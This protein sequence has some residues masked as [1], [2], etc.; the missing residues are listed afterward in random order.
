MPSLTMAIS[1]FVL[2][3]FAVPIV[4]CKSIGGQYYV[5]PNDTKTCVNDLVAWCDGMKFS[6]ERGSISMVS[7][8]MVDSTGYSQ[9]LCIADSK[10][11][12]CTKNGSPWLNCSNTNQLFYK[13]NALAKDSLEGTDNGTCE[14][15]DK[16]F[17]DLSVQNLNSDNSMDLESGLGQF[18]REL[19]GR[20]AGM[21]GRGFPFYNTNYPNNPGPS[22]EGTETSPVED[23][24]EKE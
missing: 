23:H 1:A 8:T 16:A 12:N 22:D 9:A 7:V 20:F 11:T 4:S 3:A 17:N 6:T 21:F 14:T 13:G 5:R 10:G 2:V 19:Q 18:F 15:A 24:R